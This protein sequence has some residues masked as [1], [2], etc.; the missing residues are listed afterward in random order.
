MTA[1]FCILVA[2]D[3]PAVREALRILLTN[4]DIGLSWRLH[5]ARYYD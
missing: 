2:D 3:Q 5:L 4:A 1:L